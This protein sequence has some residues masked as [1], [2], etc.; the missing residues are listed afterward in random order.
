MKKY[1]HIRVKKETLTGVVRLKGMLEAAS[2]V[3]ISN[4]KA[5]DLAVIKMTEDLEKKSKKEKDKIVIG[6]IRKCSVME[7]E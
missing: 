4:D 1:T 5:V 6:L 3:Q 7:Q 2:G